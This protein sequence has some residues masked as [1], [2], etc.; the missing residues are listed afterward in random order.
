MQYLLLLFATDKIRNPA[1]FGQNWLLKNF[2]IRIYN[3]CGGGE[4]ITMEMND[5]AEVG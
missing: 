2:C 1:F 4:Y 3:K 5:D